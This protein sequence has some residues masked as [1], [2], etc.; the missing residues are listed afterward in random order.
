MKYFK[1]VNP[2]Y[3]S[4]TFYRDEYYEYALPI[5]P[6]KIC[7]SSGLYF[8]A[9]GIFTVY[10]YGTLVYEVEPVGWIYQNPKEPLKYEAD[11]LNMKLIG[12]KWDL[13]VIK[14]LIEN[15]AD[16][17]AGDDY[18]LRYS[19]YIGHFEVVKFLVEN[20]ANISARN[21]CALINAA[22][23][24]HFEIVEFLMEKDKDIH[25]DHYNNIIRYT[26]NK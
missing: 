10:D 18:I 12:K 7:Q 21:D 22:T 23:Y 15:G 8:S 20:G 2:E 17:H 5:N 26:S 25:I 3:D 11:V 16:I 13:D 6:L 19:A 24:G 14:Y 9:K 4:K 1:I